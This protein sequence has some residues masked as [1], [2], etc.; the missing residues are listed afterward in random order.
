MKTTSMTF[1]TLEIEILEAAM[2]D[3]VSMIKNMRHPDDTDNEY[4]AAMYTLQTKI[5]TK[6]VKIFGEKK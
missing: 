2:A 3:H 5:N 4:G 1:T 6:A